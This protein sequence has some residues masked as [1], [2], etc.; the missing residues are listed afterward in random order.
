MLKSKSIRCTNKN[1]GFPKRQLERKSGRRHSSD[2][3]KEE[4]ANN[5]LSLQIHLILFYL[6]F[7]FFTIFQFFAIFPSAKTAEKQQHQQHNKD[8]AFCAHSLSF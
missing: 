5:Q 1:D 3:E 4:G 6:D 7:F 2:G 8:E